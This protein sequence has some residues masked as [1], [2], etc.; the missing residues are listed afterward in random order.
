MKWIKSAAS[1]GNPAAIQKI[2]QSMI[3]GEHG[4]KKEPEKALPLL[5]QLSGQRDPWA[6]ATLGAYYAC[7]K[8]VPMDVKKARDLFQKGAEQGDTQCLYLYGDYLM[9][10]SLLKA[11][12][13][14]KIATNDSPGGI[15][16]ARYEECLKQ[17]SA[18]EIAEGDKE[19]ESLVRKFQSVK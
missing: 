3:L 1:S 11:Y 5:E 4:V 2:A 19:A 15:A 7:G 8:L 18:E 13:Y 16:Q 9:S 14:L 10:E 12:P 6:C 17:L